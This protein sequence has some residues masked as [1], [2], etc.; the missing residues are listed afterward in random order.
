MGR[1]QYKCNNRTHPLSHSPD[2]G[3]SVQNSHS[4]TPNPSQ[5]RSRPTSSFAPV[6]P[7]FTAGVP[8]PAAPF[9]QVRSPVVKRAQREVIVRAG[10]L[11]A[12]GSGVITGVVV[13][14]E[15][16]KA[17]MPSRASFTNIQAKENIAP[18]NART[19]KRKAD[20]DKFTTAKRGRQG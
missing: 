6:V 8:A 11:A 13:A 15:E 10:L 18:T 5:E 3:A 12:L 1:A 17:D 7:S 19:Q 14:L 16:K 9:T 2:S 20:V 4:T